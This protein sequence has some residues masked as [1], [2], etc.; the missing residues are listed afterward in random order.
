MAVA[1]RSIEL[2]ATVSATASLRRERAIWLMRR[3]KLTEARQLIE[4]VLATLMTAADA[5]ESAL[6]RRALANADWLLA[7]PD[8]DERLRESEAEL[9][10]L[11]LSVPPLA[12]I[13][14]RRETDTRRV[15]ETSGVERLLVPIQ[16]LTTRGVGVNHLHKELVSITTELFPGRHVVLTEL[17]G[18]GKCTELVARPGKGVANLGWFE[19]EDGLGRVLRLGVGEVNESGGRGLL[20]VV[21]A[22]AG[23][24]LEIAA[25]RSMA[26]APPRRPESSEKRADFGR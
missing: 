11:N 26:I 8:A 6:A 22:C 14:E 19:V 5:G 1:Q 9:A 2:S 10:S 16:R 4:V 21:A 15:Y 18:H 17:M 23:M 24:A 12:Q 7:L 25:L 3:G 20:E 13:E